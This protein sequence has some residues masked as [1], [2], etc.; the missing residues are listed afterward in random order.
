MLHLNLVDN[1]HLRHNYNVPGAIYNPALNFN[2]LGIPKL[3]V[4]FNDKDYIP[5]NS[6]NSN[7]STAKSSGCRLHLTWDHNKHMHS[8]T[9]WYCTLPEILLYQG[10]GYFSAFCLRL[11]R[12]YDDGIASFYFSAFSI[13]PSYDETTGAV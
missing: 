6:I 7:G 8:F 2:L 9:H 3:A 10:H 5:G 11:R 12:C 13:S 1:A 4:Y